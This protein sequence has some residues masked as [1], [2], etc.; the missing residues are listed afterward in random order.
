[1]TKKARMYAQK[2][3]LKPKHT[4]YHQRLKI[5]V[6]ALKQK[7]AALGN[8][9]KRYHKRSKRYQQNNLFISDQREFFRQLSEKNNTPTTT[10]TLEDLNKYWTSVWS[11]GKKHNSA[12]V[13]INT[14]KEEQS[15]TRKM[16]GINVTEEDVK[17]T[18][19]G[20]K[21]WTSPGIDGIHNFWW[22]SLSST[23]KVL[24]KFI[25]RAVEIPTNVP[26]YFTQGITILI[27]KK[28]DLALSENY[29]PI[30]CLP[31]AYK[32]LTSTIAHKIR[33]HL[34]EN[35]I[36]AWEQN[37][38]KKR[39]RG[40]KELLAIDNAITKQAKKK[41][42]NIS[43]A[44][45][46]YQ[47]AFDSVPHSWLLEILAIYKIHP[48]VIRLL[49]SLMTTW[50]TSLKMKNK[51]TLN[52][53]SPIK[54]RKGIFQG[55][56]LSPLW[57]CLALNPLSRM[58]NRSAYGYSIDQTN[59][60]T[61]LFYMDDLKLYARG[62]RHLEG[63][64]ELVRQFSADIGM[65]F[66]LQKCAA[67]DVRKGKLVREEDVTLSDGQII[68]SM[69]IEDRY[70]YL[71]VQQTYEVKEKENKKGVEEQMMT[72]VKKI[73]TSQLSAKNK[74]TA[75]NIWALPA[76]TYTAGILKWS[77][78]DLERL[79]R[80]V[81]T[82]FTQSGILHPNSAIERL[83]L[84]RSIGG[85]GLSSIQ[86]SYLKENEKIKTYFDKGYLPVHR[87]LSSLS[88]ACANPDRAETSEPVEE[89]LDEKWR[90]QWQAKP[91]HGR[92]YANLHQPEVDIKTS[93]TYLTQGYL[94]PQTE[95]TFLAIQDQVVPT[96]VYTK[97]IMKQN[98]EST[99]CRLC[100]QEE[101]SIQHLSSGCST[102]ASTKYLN[103]HNNMG[104]V[105][106]QLICL[107]ERLVPHFTPHHVYSPQALLENNDTKIYWDIPIITD[108][109]VENNRPDVVVW[110]KKK[111]S[112][113]II[114]FAVPLDQNLGKSYR[115]K[116]AKYETLARQIK[117]MWNL[118]RVEIKPLIISCNGLVHKKTVQHLQ[119]LQLP[120]NA[121][122]W[123]QK[124]VVL[125]TVNI[126][127]Q[128]LYSY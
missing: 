111:N 109:S 39:G 59:K 118:Q 104:K 119:E 106:H 10:A 117:I 102:I 54:I 7:I 120:N 112:A 75:I 45:I 72:R 76:F 42:K 36:M 14:E 13:W 63:E 23:H 115:E 66:G 103:R 17:T 48:K 69:G 108:Q 18:T 19:K 40:S 16:P 60:L 28:G 15:N 113:I 89:S 34:N 25:Q 29:R 87:L 65:K 47:K 62:R 24:A 85:R 50:R 1:M 79:D 93:N 84:P 6:E 99:K 46:D 128:V 122:C 35:Q 78:T 52:L 55:D 27:P 71:G 74:I 33:K 114:D 3:K 121:I 58:L 97:H 70:K 124:A 101:E 21:N 30:T 56:S 67:V 51:S 126:I 123:M 116:V 86:N 90:Q 4:E 98:I 94:F 61:H 49:K 73:L 82:A 44:W 96:R 95:G 22:K 9:L 5:H 64:L 38:S 26:E 92:F 105:V 31:S 81:R 77:K 8:R 88:G 110:D 37:G 91:L 53:T 32:I 2:L 11:Q 127:R 57:F 83:Y 68:E 80:R 125:G 12:A 43:M 41:S 20:L 107:K 100:N